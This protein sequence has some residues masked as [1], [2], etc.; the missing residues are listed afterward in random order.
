MVRR[1]R[2]RKAPVIAI[3][4]IIGC[5]IVLV[6]ALV[7]IFRL[8]GEYKHVAEVNKKA[9]ESITEPA[10][11]DDGGGE[12]KE[13]F[14]Y[15]HEAALK[16]NTDAKGMYRNDGTQTLLPVVQRPDDDDHYLHLGFDGEYSRG[17][18]LFIA[19]EIKE[20]L[21]ASHVIIY[22]HHMN[23]D[24]MFTKNNNYKDEDFY[25]QGT[26]DT[27][28]IYTP[29]VLR[30]Y[31]IFAVY[32]SDPD[33]PVY[34]INMNEEELKQFALECAERSMYNTGVDISKA[35]QIVT[36]SSCEATD[37]NYRLVV[38]GVLVKETPY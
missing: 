30:E 38:Q 32:N 7:N 31:K 28:Y 27:F 21:D 25:R 5:A 12:Q 17:G 24:S 34:T 33:G 15:N 36:L 6:I 23:D 1:R 11:I 22:G 16:I 18:T 10:K 4:V 37:Y 29:D 26:N 19:G 35:S 3:L 2:R 14:K 20:G 8:Q 9:V 13:E